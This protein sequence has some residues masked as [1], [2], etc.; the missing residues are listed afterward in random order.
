MKIGLSTTKNI[1]VFFED[2]P[3]QIKNMMLCRQGILID[4]CDIEGNSHLRRI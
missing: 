3:K 1:I 2:V 4:A